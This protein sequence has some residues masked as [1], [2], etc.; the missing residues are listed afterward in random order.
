MINLRIT[1]DHINPRVVWDA[2]YQY[3]ESEEMTSWAKT[4]IPEGNEVHYQAVVLNWR[5]ALL[6]ESSAVLSAI[7]IK[8]YDQI[9]IEIWTL[10]FTANMHK[11]F[12]RATTKHTANSTARTGKG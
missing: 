5:G 2:K 4:K 8:P 6:K 9:I 11:F 7:G 12:G 10:A 1:S 3:Y